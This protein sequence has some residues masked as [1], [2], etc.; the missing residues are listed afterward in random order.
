MAT[1]GQND[2]RGCMIF[3]I[4]AILRSSVSERNVAMSGTAQQ[5]SNQ[6][7]KI[8]LAEQAVDGCQEVTIPSGCCSHTK[9]EGQK[10]AWWRVNLGEFITINYITIYYRDNFQ[11]RFAGYQL[12]VSNTTSSPQD[13]VLCFEDTSR[14]RGALQL[15]VTHLCPNVSQYVTVYNYR[16]NPTRQDWYD[17]HAVLELCEVQ[18]WG[19]PVGTYGDGNCDSACSGNCYGG[20]CNATTGTCF[21]CVPQTYGAKCEQNCSINCKDRL[22][23]KENGNCNECI[24]GKR[25]Y[26]CD[27]DCPDTCTKCA[28]TTEH[29]FECSIGKHG[30]QCELDCSVNCKEKCDKTTGNCQGE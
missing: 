8:W 2:L 22:C 17:N 6:N 28:Q 15:N 24:D 18:V 14:T 16:S 9:A 20:N 7:D 21:Y 19:C 3:I 11:Q 4:F 1:T 27:L 29:C 30:A 13:G 10:T 23:M 26:R 12:Y 25:G 5:S